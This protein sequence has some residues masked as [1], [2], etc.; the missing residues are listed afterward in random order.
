ML[1]LFFIILLKIS[2]FV[3]IISGM[4]LYI[5]TDA[6]LKQDKIYTDYTEINLCQNSAKT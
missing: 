3:A 1:H 4:C 5:E 2:T 6:R